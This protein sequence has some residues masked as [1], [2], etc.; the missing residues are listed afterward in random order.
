MIIDLN[1]INQLT[2]ENV[3]KLIASKDDSMDRQLRVSKEGIA[4]ISEVVAADDIYNLAF[5]FDTWDSGNSYFGISASE[6]EE[7]VRKVF[8][9]LK[10]NWPNPSSTQIFAW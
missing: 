4:F 5:R 10:A 6:D 8:L 2:E 3:K 7:W 9:S 1:N